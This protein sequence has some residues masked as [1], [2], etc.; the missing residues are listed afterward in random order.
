MQKSFVDRVE[1]VHIPKLMAFAS[2]AEQNIQQARAL[3]TSKSGI[4]KEL[5]NNVDANEVTKKA[6]ELYA[7]YLREQAKDVGEENKAAE[8]AVNTAL[9]TY[10]TVKLSSDVASLIQS[11]RGEFD[12][13]M[14]LSVPPM[15]GFE[16]QKLRNELKLITR[17]L[18]R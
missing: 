17:E 14:K 3:I 10:M 18:M 5:L 6:A 2:Q 8:K 15:K 16:N 11:G 12:S 1:N 9:N 4:R 13:L 7:D